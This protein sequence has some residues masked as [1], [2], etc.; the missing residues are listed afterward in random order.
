[1]CVYIAKLYQRRQ[2][3]RSPGVGLGG[4]CMWYYSYTIY[5]TILYYTFIFY[6]YYCTIMI[7]LFVL[8]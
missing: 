4:S 5:Y 7:L 3:T 6:V 8:W 2:F 1:M